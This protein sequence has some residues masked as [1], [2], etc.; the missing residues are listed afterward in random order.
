[1]VNLIVHIGN[2]KTGSVPSKKRCWPAGR[3]LAAFTPIRSGSSSTRTMSI[4][5]FVDRLPIFGEREMSFAGN[6]SIGQLRWG[7]RKSVV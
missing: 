3:L 4:R 6:L 2:G 5:R 1:M 7:D